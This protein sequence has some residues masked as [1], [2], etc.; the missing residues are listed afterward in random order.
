VKPSVRADPEL[1]RRLAILAARR[2][3]LVLV[4]VVEASGSAPGKAGAKMIVTA[5]GLE[6]TVGGGKIEQAAIGRARELLGEMAPP[7]I[8]EYHVTQDLGMTCGGSMTLLYE[9]IT[10]P[11]RLVIFGA[12]HVSQALCGMAALAGF[13][14]IVCDEREEWLT[15][16]RFPEARERVLGPLTDALE[17]VLLDGNTFVCCV[18]PG[19]ASD[20]SIL[21]DVLKNGARPRYVGA[22]GSRRKAVLLREGLMARGVSKD[23]AEGIHVPMGLDIGAVDPREIAVSVLAEMIAVLRGVENLRPWK[24]G[25]SEDP[26]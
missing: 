3:P 11:P 14:V 5:A 18:T 10:A 19:H 15:E 1:L 23:D 25:V 12:G 26:A 2:E 16:E 13:D 17:R 24:A 4:T 7:S 8:K 6:G 20:E 21:L 22:I 9:S